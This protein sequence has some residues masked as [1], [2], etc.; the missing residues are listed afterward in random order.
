MNTGK[1]GRCFLVFFFVFLAVGMPTSA[2]A[3]SNRFAPPEAVVLEEFDDLQ[4]SIANLA[5]A[6]LNKG[7]RNSLNKKLERAEAAYKKGRPCTAV[8]I[9]G[10]F[11]NHTGALVRGKKVVIAEELRNRGWMLRHNLLASLPQQVSC[12]GFDDVEAVAELNIRESNNQS[13]SASVSFGKALL[14]TIEASGEVWTHVEIPSLQSLVGKPGMPAVPTWQTLLAVPMEAEV[15][16]NMASPKM[17]EEIPLHLYPFQYQPADSSSSDFEFA[18]NQSVYGQQDFYP[19][20]PCSI[21][22]LGQVRDL[23]IAQLTCAAGQYNPSTRSM[24]FFDSID[25][26]IVFNGGNGAFI[27]SQTLSPFEE[28]SEAVIADVANRE[29]VRDYV[30]VKDLSMLT[31]PGEELLILT[32]PDFTGAAL[33]LAAWKIEKGIS[34]SV[35]EVGPGTGYDDADEIDDLIEW[36]YDNCRVRPSYILLLGDVGDIVDGEYIEYIPPSRQDVDTSDACGPCDD[37]T[38]GSDYAYALYP[39][40]FDIFPDFAVGRIPVD[41]PEEA[42]LVVDKIIQ[43][44]SEPPF[45]PG[46][47]AP[48]YTTTTHASAFQCCRINSDGTP[49]NDQPGTDQRAFIETSELVRGHLMESGYEVERIY[50]KT[51]EDGCNDAT[52]NRYYNGSL[53]PDDLRSGS[54]FP[55]DGDTDDIIDCFNDGRF[56]ILHRDHGLKV[57]FAHPVFNIY[58]L[59]DLENDEFLPVLYSVNCLSGMFDRES[60]DP[61]RE[62]KNECF[63]EQ[64]LLLDGAG[65][66]GGLGVIRESPTWANDAMTRGIY[67][68]TWPEVAPEFG[69]DASKR[70]LGDILNHGKMYLLTQL[71]VEQTAEAISWEAAFGDLAMWHVFGDPTMEMWTRNPY[72]LTL[73]FAHALEVHGDH[74][75]VKYDIAGAIITAFQETQTGT[76]PIGR[77][78]VKN[79]SAVIPYFSKP[80]PGAPI[81]LSAS[82]ENAVSVQLGEVQYGPDLVVEEIQLQSTTLTQGTNLGG[83]LKL[84]IAN[85]GNNDSPGTVNPDGSPKNPPEG[86]M[87]DLV[88]SRDTQV[89]EGFA[90]PA[91]EIGVEF[92]EDALLVGGRVSRTLD[93]TAMSS[94]ILPTGPIVSSDVGGIIPSQTPPGSYYLCAR[95]DP[96]EAVQETDEVNNLTCLQITVVGAQ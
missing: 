74:L 4:M 12:P 50:T 93:V 30:L 79:G 37:E 1:V 11:L 78:T 17:G 58:N 81:T 16:L 24:R 13:F 68:A 88:L 6:E 52:P 34:T 51:V 71:A 25:V 66:V 22:I 20:E 82:F 19:A 40:F 67:D 91:D 54:D 8:N 56:L 89:P 94:V 29:V 5:P 43:Y 72:L 76:V 41:T 65:M 7:I 70:R 85:L 96:G 32:H 36:R 84:K 28:S 9:L 39:A 14:H 10:A 33:D 92:D 27:T 21:A 2:V 3:K 60:D 59:P 90:T 63:M 55:W 49:F 48:F 23:T 80:L 61:D 73:L 45:L 15:Y 69:D 53:L 62:T 77:G 86:Y 57:G 47:G 75:D 46:D 38:T 95:I 31:C 44:E 26:E 42:Q 35:R 64:L 87:I 83:V 18:V